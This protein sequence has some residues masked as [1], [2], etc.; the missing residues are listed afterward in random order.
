M[1]SRSRALRSSLER[2]ASAVLRAC[3]VDSAESI[4]FLVDDATAP[5]LVGAFQRAISELDRF[6]DTVTL[7]VQPR[8]PAFA[9][10]PGLAV[11]ALL[12]ANLVLDLTTSPWLYSDSFTRYVSECRNRESRLAMIW[13]NR[14][15]LR[16]IAACAP[17]PTLVVQARAGLVALEH[18]RTLRVRSSFGTDFTVQLGERASY[19]RSF[20]GEPPVHAGMTSA[21]LCASV[22]APFV[23]GTAEGSLAFSGAGRIQGPENR[24]LRSDGPV[25]LTIEAGHIARID[26]D[27]AA[28]ILLAD[29]LARGPAGD[30]TTLM[31]CNI[32]FD[33]RAKLAWADNTVVHSHAGGVMIGFG[34]PYQY[35]PEGSRR[36]GYHLD[37]MFSGADVD[38]DDVAF[39]RSGRFVQRRV[40]D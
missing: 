39:I 21:P 31:D 10:L 7:Q 8:Q 14:G 20:I 4:L 27:H 25:L 3:E 2:T 5:L 19:P 11:E 23:P 38:L 35:R 16:T 30:V 36:S 32:G 34:N 24:P 26:G 15:S 6:A 18:T 9:D 13:G 12:R 29:W 1:G 17:S 40:S 33:P 22:T 37:L 28:A